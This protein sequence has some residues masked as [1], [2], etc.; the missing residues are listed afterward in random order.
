MAIKGSNI[1]RVILFLTILLVLTSLAYA[2]PSF[3]LPS[4]LNFGEMTRNTT[5]NVSFTISN[6]GDVQLTNILVS[7]N[8]PS[9]YD[10]TF[11]QTAAFSL[12]PSDSKNIYAAIRVPANADTGS[13]LS[14]GSVLLNSDQLNGSIPIKVSVS[15]ALA[16]TEVRMSIDYS[17]SYAFRK[18]SDRKDTVS[19]I[20][21]NARLDLD[22]E[23]DSTITM[24]IKV[25]NK[26]KE[27]DNDI[28][29]VQA[30]VTLEEIDDG[31]DIEAESTDLT[32]ADNEEQWLTV[33]LKIPKKVE[34]KTYTMN[35]F[36]DGSGEDGETH[37]DEWNIEVPIVKESH[38]VRFE[39]VNLQQNVLNC[40][41][42]T[43]LA[44]AIYNAGRNA[45]NDL[46]LE[47]KNEDLYLNYIRGGIYLDVEK[48]EE[49]SS[50]ETTVPIAVG[51]QIKNGIYPMEVNIYWQG[52]VLFDQRKVDLEVTGCAQAE[53]PKPEEKKEPEPPANEEK[54]EGEIPVVS[55]SP[56]EN[57]NA[58][59]PNQEEN[60][61]G[62]ETITVSKEFSF[63]NSPLYWPVILGAN[64][65]VLV[66]I[67]AVAAYF[68]RNR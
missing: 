43:N 56:S 35:I 45:E 48:F 40:G 32:L 13:N 58:P 51:N 5:K 64:L 12:N 9:Q 67:F 46:K 66:G 17:Q 63:R 19:G 55:P 41:S 22:I 65:L 47:V 1:G 62:Q 21:D 60:E 3:S 54:D 49:E 2:V 37:S 61:G 57:S 7:S 29:G 10:A 28:R 59:N 34:Q 31:D 33:Q 23:P 30:T 27:D 26:L 44:V 53:T 42:S 39:N 16:I 20:F 50:F 15:K 25:E 36:V 38:D 52:S 14:I 11:D 6:N 68:L 18:S 4:E 8:A 24:D